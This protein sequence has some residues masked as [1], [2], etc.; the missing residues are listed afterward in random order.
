MWVTINALDAKVDINQLINLHIF[1][2]KSLFWGHS[3]SQIWDLY[4]YSQHSV[5]SDV[6]RGMPMESYAMLKGLSNIYVEV[7]FKVF[8]VPL[9][10]SEGVCF[11]LY[12][13]SFFFSFY[14]FYM[15]TKCWKLY[16][17]HCSFDN[18]KWLCGILTFPMCYFV[19]RCIVCSSK[20]VLFFI[21]FILLFLHIYLSQ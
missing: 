15:Y 2:V 8:F 14:Y 18:A 20:S 10:E 16:I 1:H 9:W 4:H 7:L 6:Y 13:M 11:L 17:L 3:Y 5:I 21:I 19:L 12:Y